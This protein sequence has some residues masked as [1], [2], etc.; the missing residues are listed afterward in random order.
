MPTITRGSLLTLEAYAK[1]R[2]SSK[3]QVIAP[4]RM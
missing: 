4:R 3:P 1:N 2:N